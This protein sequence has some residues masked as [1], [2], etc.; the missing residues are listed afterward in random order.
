MKSIVIILMLIVGTT[1]FADAHKVTFDTIARNEGFRSNVYRC[2]AG[3]LTI[4]YGFTAK[5]YV[6]MKYMSKADADKVLST[7]VDA[8]LTS[9]DSI[10]GITVTLNDNQKAVLA[11]MIY[12]FG[13]GAIH[14]A[15]DLIAAINSGDDTKVAAQLGR[16]NKQKK[17]DKDGKLVKDSNGKQVY[18]T[19]AGLTNRQA[20]LVQL[21]RTK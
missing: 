13:S 14:N 17:R 7:Y 8:C 3:K 12:H 21:W 10:K 5:Q 9:V 19:V 11:D 20:R 18:E 4:G 16:W 6:D 1:V 15:T 2:S